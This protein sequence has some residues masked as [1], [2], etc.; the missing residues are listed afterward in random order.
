MKLHR[1]NHTKDPFFTLKQGV[2]FKKSPRTP[3][4]KI[5]PPPN[6]LYTLVVRYF[7]V[8][9]L[10][11]YPILGPFGGTP[12]KRPKTPFLALPRVFA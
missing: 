7:S 5:A 10:F 1:K 4:C 6:R 3:F 12:P 8:N 2:N 9:I 11:R